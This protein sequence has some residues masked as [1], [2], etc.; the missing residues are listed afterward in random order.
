MLVVVLSLAG[1][2]G[3]QPSDQRLSFGLLPCAGGGFERQGGIRQ[4]VWELVKRT[5][6]EAGAD[7]FP[8]DPASPE[9]YRTPFLLWSCPGPVAE[10]S[11]R[12]ADGLAAFL[13]NGGFLW[14]DDPS[15]TGTGPF[16]ESLRRRFERVLP[17]R[18]WSD[19]PGGHVLYKTFF[20][21][22]RPLGRRAGAP[23][24]AIV[25][26]DRLVVLFTGGDV[27]GAM[28][29]DLTGHWDFDCQPGGEPQREESFRL[30]INIVMYAL[31]L[32]YKNDRVHLPFIMRR[33]RL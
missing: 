4:L 12:Q 16:A 2:A 1:R 20:L 28:S 31:C 9:L 29:R 26:E 19:I 10:L 8:V 24:R 15:G 22:K 23:R 11:D 21:I 18:K 5:S 27:L 32:D 6:V 17:G 25:I 14:A 7:V 3:A 33:R 30:G 13:Q